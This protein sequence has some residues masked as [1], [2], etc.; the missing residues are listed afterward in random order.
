MKIGTER[1]ITDLENRV[2]GQRKL[3]ERHAVK[4]ERAEQQKSILIVAITRMAIEMGFKVTQCEEK[5]DSDQFQ[6]YVTVFYPSGPV[7]FQLRQHERPLFAHLT[8][9]PNQSGVGLW[10][11]ANEGWQKLLSGNLVARV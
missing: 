4:L 6:L 11:D 10:L 9:E 1:I 8:F 5:D 2:E 7:V 3:L